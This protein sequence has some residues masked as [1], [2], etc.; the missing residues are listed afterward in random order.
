M[1]GNAFNGHIIAKLRVYGPEG[2]VDNLHALYPYILATDGMYERGTEEATVQCAVPVF[3]GFGV[4]GFQVV[5]LLEHGLVLVDVSL[6]VVPEV[7][8]DAE[9]SVHHALPCPSSVPSPL[10]VM[11]SASTA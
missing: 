10:M 2:R 1:D 6:A 3:V 7:Y 11:F 9:N 8:K 5:F 4:K